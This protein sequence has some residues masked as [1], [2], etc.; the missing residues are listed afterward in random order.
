[1]G[2]G[3]G[4]TL[5]PGA[6]VLR[7]RSGVC[8]DKASMSITLLRAA[9]Y[10]VYPAMTM[11]GSRVERIPAD[12]FNHCVVA[13]RQG[14]DWKMLDPTWVTFSPEEWSSA[15]GEQH[16]VIGTPQGETLTM[17][18]TFLPEDNKLVVRAETALAADGTLTGT[19]TF[20]GLGYAEQRLRR[21]LVHNAATA[22]RQAWFEEALSPLGPTVEVE[23]VRVSYAAIQDVHTPI[24]YTARFRVPGYAAVTANG[25]VFAPPTAAHLVANSRLA[26]YLGLAG[27]ES[28]TQGLLLWA[29]RMRDVKETL[30]LPAGF[31][32]ARLPVDR[33]LDHEVASLATHAEVKGRKLTYTQD[34]RVKHRTIPPEAYPDFKEVVQAAI[35]LPTDVVVLER[36]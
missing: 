18:P 29:P 25:L 14:E 6:M 28:R 17:T 31:T 20:S 11:A 33:A 5:H 30:T 36:R 9:G 16:Y 1:M 23:P 10:T 19:V 32:V 34:F 35:D 26:P 22:D 3:E 27:E 12:Q 4:Y 24:S 21:E 7:D 2:K 8:K 13:L 15:E